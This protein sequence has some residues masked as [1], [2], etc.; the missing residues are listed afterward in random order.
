M[1]N[2][3]FKERKEKGSNV[4]LNSEGRKSTLILLFLIVYVVGNSKSLVSFIQNYSNI[5]RGEDWKN[6]NRMPLFQP[7]DFY[8]RI[9]IGLLINYKFFLEHL[10]ILIFCSVRENYRKEFNKNLRYFIIIGGWFF[11]CCIIL[12]IQSLIYNR[13]SW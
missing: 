2:E 10:C 11:L 8:V 1:L 12:G 6:D 13:V 7:V 9:E 4:E 5:K 3:I